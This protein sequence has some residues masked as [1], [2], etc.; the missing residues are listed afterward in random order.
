MLLL[1]TLSLPKDSLADGD[2]GESI[3]DGLGVGKLINVIS[4]CNF[5]IL[6]TYS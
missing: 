2:R 6:V 4:P 5:A 3:V 1:A